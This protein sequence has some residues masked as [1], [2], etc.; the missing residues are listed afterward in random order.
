M[1]FDQMTHAVYPSY[2]YRKYIV[3]A[4]IVDPEVQENRL[5]I[6]IA[7]HEYFK[8]RFGLT[9]FKYYLKDIHQ[10]YPSNDPI[11]AITRADLD[12]IAK[13]HL[14]NQY[15]NLTRKADKAYLH[16]LELLETLDTASRTP[17]PVERS[18][19]PVER[20]LTPVDTSP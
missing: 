2:D 11:E 1:R 15:R 6:R 5:A 16:Q 13:D 19:S 4:R 10:L 8:T 18:P 12:T 17:S 9:V 20:S 3:P 14:L 7:K